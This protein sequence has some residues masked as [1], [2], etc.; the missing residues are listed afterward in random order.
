MCH[1]P[2]FVFPEIRG[3]FKCSKA[4]ECVLSP[5]K[6]GLHVL[7]LREGFT[8][9]GHCTPSTCASMHRRADLSASKDVCC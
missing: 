1:K 2:E 3:G 7:S 8:T 5:V 9:Y 4:L 6:E